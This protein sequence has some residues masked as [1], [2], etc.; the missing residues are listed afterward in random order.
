MLNSDV[1]HLK[2]RLE[3]SSAEYANEIELCLHN[4]RILTVEQKS[5]NYKKY[6][7]L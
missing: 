7:M 6:S 3:N 4:L 2:N 5:D 1:E